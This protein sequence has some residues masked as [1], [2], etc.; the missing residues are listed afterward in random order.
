MSGRSVIIEQPTLR[1][2]RKRYADSLVTFLAW[3]VWVY[4]WLPLVSLAAWALGLRYA[5]MHVFLAQR[6]S[7][8]TLGSYSLVVASMGVLLVA[9]SRYN[10]RR[11]GR[12]ARRR[13]PSP[14]RSVRWR[15][16]SRSRSIG[17]KDFAGPRGWPWCSIRKA[18]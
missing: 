16:T 4:I 12:L 1:Q 2:A 11:F 14:R 15:N 3:L 9:W 6:P 17:S 18:W 7:F 8:E 5:W 13:A 10:L